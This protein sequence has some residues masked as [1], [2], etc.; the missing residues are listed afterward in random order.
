MASFMNPNLFAKEFNNQ[1]ETKHQENPDLTF[2]AA[3][4]PPSQDAHSDSLQRHLP[5]WL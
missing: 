2:F 5:Q 1:V 4:G 3:S